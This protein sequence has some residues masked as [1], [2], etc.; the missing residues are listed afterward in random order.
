MT[1]GTA[2]RAI[3]VVRERTGRG[4][5][6]L[7]I[8]AI[9]VVV[10]FLL[11]PVAL[12]VARSFSDSP[13]GN[14]DLLPL[15]W[16]NYGAI[17]ESWGY[18]LGRFGKTLLL[19]GL[20]ALL[21]ALVAY[22]LALGIV[23]TRSRALRFTYVFFALTPLL[24]SVVIR[25]FGWQVILGPTGP[26][27]QFAPGTNG[28]LSSDLAVVIGLGH[29]AT[30]FVLLSLLPV[31]DNLDHSLIRAAR[32]LGAGAVRVFL[33]VVLTMSMPGLVAGILVSFSVGATVVVTPQLLGGRQN[34]L[35]PNL[36]FDQMAQFFDW[37]LA[38]SLSTLLMLMIGV[39]SFVIGLLESWLSPLARARRAVA[40]SGR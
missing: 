11:V 6:Y 15:T 14:P 33:K 4:A 7:L 39:V 37:N 3:G 35:V 16:D 5:A 24:V 34:Q 2:T 18:Y 9:L 12:L 1:A 38:A 25:T 31:L 30:P 36:I 17:L 22:P 32:G 13:A 21:G 19:A 10:V 29:L 26:V 27:G 40:L 8:P 23:S 28:F 20:G